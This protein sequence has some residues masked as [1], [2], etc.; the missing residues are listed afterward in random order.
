L[1]GFR[2]RERAIASSREIVLFNLWGRI[3]P[4]DTLRFPFGFAVDYLS[5]LETRSLGPKAPTTEGR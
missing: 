3:A 4:Q 2:A 5:L 1:I